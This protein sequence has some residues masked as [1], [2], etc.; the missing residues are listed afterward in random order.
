MARRGV[1]DGVDSRAATDELLGGLRRGGFGGRALGAFVADATLRSIREARK[2]PIAL[3]EATAVHVGMAALAHPHGRVWIATSWLMTVTHLGML[4]HR[5]SMG[6]P[7]LLT[8]A[9]AN[10]PAAEARLGSVQIV[11]LALVTD[12]VDGKLARRTGTVTRF[13]TQGDYLADAALW[14]WFTVKHEPSRGWQLATLAAWAIPVAGL[15]IAS[16]AKGGMVDVPRSRWLRPAAAIE[17]LIGARVLARIVGR[18][19]PG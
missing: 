5:T 12:F 8:I 19:R 16:F 9:R 17:V 7:N 6:L 13:G 14:T 11:A 18:R 10:L 15:T 3:A 2:R 1:L 4:E